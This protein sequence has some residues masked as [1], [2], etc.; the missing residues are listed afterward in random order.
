MEEKR[1]LLYRLIERF[2]T[3]D[4]AVIKCSEELDMLILNSYIQSVHAE[5]Y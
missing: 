5:C 2:G 3:K 1:E 4:P